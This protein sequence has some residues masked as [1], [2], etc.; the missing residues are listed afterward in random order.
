MN[1]NVFQGC[2]IYI[3]PNGILPKRAILFKEQ[4]LK[5]GGSVVS[6][7]FCSNPTHIVVEDEFLMNP[8]AVKA[9]LNYNNLKL[10]DI[11][12]DIVSTLWLSKCLKEKKLLSTRNFCFKNFRNIHNNETSTKIEPQN[13]IRKLKESETSCTTTDGNNTLNEVIIN[14][15][16]KLA[17]A[18][19]VKGDRWRTLA[20]DKA[21]I[22]LKSLKKPITSMN[23]LKLLPNVSGKMMDKISEIMEDGFC[24]KVQDI[25]DEKTQVLEMFNKIWGVGSA[26]AQQW[27]QKGCRSLEDLEI[28]VNL[29]KQ[30]KLGLK[31]F[32]EIQEPVPREEVK[33]IIK[34]V[35]N[36]ALDL[37]NSLRIIPCGSYRRGN[38]MC[39]DIDVLIIVP[40]CINYQVVIPI[41]MSKLKEKEFL[42]DDLQGGKEECLSSKYLGLCK[43]PR[44][45]SKIRRLDLFTVPDREAAC[46]LLHYTGSSI[47]NRGIRLHASKMNMKLTESALVSQH[48]NTKYP[49]GYIIPTPTEESVFEHLNLHYKLPEDRFYFSA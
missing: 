35:E 26:T 38:L 30:Q 31:Y 40:D 42:I 33:Q 16:Q 41:L 3:L 47:F 12:C 43:L 17:E 37:E 32:S 14:E 11:Q 2:R 22:S 15:L 36:T 44:E 45:N 39:G 46:A 25:C 10:E 5:H 9:V 1:E 34:F 18:Y 29:T 4:I 49:A 28:K 21:V 27:Y 23:D 7:K 24:S 13:K 6:D 19:R 20:Y 8:A 48:G